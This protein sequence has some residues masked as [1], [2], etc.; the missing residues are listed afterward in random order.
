MKRLIL[1]FLGC[2]LLLSTASCKR[3]KYTEVVEVPLP[4]KESKIQIGQPD[5]VKAD[6]GAFSLYKLPF[7]YSDLDP[8]IDAYTMEL[9]YSRHYLNTTN[10][11]NKLLTERGSEI[12]STQ[13]FF[14]KLN[15]ADEPLRNNAG[16]YYNHTLYFEIMSPKG[17]GKPKD[18]LATTINR[19]FGSFENLKKQLSDKANAQFGSGWAWLLV[20]KTGRLQVTTTSNNDNPLMPKQAVS[21]IPI[22]CIDVWE[23]AYYLS[24][25]NQ[26]KKYIDNFF[27]VVDW[28]K[29]EEKFVAAI[30][31]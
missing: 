29:V 10:A 23:H 3:K 12:G 7:K 31:K 22:L 5:E 6:K 24:Y 1:F 28:K 8:T 9:H 14:K 17:G 18:T 30:K 27:K 25:Q 19:D 4:A 11:L 2:A 15:L 20:D 26:R 21:G 16:G 13:E